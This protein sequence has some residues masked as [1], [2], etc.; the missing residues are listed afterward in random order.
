MNEELTKEVSDLEIKEAILLIGPDKASGHDGFSAS[1]FRHFWTDVGEDV[2]LMVKK[3]FVTGEL[4]PRMNHTQLCLIPKVA[5]SDQISDYKPISLCTVNY[6]IISKI[7]VLRL[8]KILGV[9]ISDNQAAFVLGRQIHDNVMV[10]HEL[11]HALKSKRDCA[12][13]YMAIKTDIRKAY[14]RVEWNFL[15]EVMRK[16]GFSEVWIRWIMT[17]VR[18]VTFSIII[19]GSDYGHVQPTRG[20]R[21]GDP[22]SPYLFLFCAETL[23][24][25]L[26]QTEA[27]K[28]FQGMTLTKHC[29]SVSHLL[30]VYDSLFFCN[31]THE[32]STR[33]AKILQEYEQVSGGGGKYLGLPEQFGRSKTKAFQ[34]IVNRVKQTVDGWLYRGRYHKISTFLE[35]SSGTNPSYGWRSI[36]ARKVLLKKGLQRQGNNG[37]MMVEELWKTGRREWDEEKLAAVLIPEDVLLAKQIRLSRY[38][39]RDEYVWPYTTRSVYS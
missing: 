6:K 15:E 2:C 1:F 14:D 24:Q 31:A 21:Q 30:F 23:S 9:I 4:E 32:D 5:D 37:K 28:E 19:N 3:F 12:E 27:R 13:K 38:A 35:S 7:L 20:I 39:E 34:G 22:L 25:M 26:R 10:A 36:Q 8:K 18:S 11:I 29:P 17:C 33:M 16:M